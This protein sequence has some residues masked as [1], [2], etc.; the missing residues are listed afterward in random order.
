MIDPQWQHAERILCVRL[1]YLGDVLMSTPAIRA[2]K[3]SIP[4]SRI[5]LLTSASGAAAARHV[6]EID[7]TIGYA[8]PWMKSSAQHEPR[9]DFALIERLARQHFDAAVIFTVYSQNPLPAAMLCHLAGI[10]LRLAHCR[11]NPYQLL[12][13]WVRET[14]P[15]TQIRHEVRR[16]LD[17]VASVGAHASDERLS[18][19]VAPPDVAWVKTRLLSLD[20][21]LTRPWIVMHPGA[22]APSRRYPPEHWKATALGLVDDLRCPLIFTGNQEEAELVEHIRREVPGTHSLAGQLDL[23]KLAAL[24]SLSPLLIC[25]NTGPAHIAAAVGVPI[26]DL[27]ALTNPQHTPW[28]VPHRVLFQDVPCRYC[29]KSVCPQ[30]HHRCLSELAPERVISAA[31]ELL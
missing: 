29:Y 8:A 28:Q 5:T 26:V 7:D 31:K 18:F 9:T 16:Q 13:N 11:E 10:P 30:G 14:E 21:D 1:D 23:G 6:P 24:L 17:L 15:E 12:T 4:G 2:L 22:T 20:I 25:N 3:E 19:H 27:Y